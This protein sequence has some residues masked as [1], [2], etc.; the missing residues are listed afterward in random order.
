MAVT[1]A[2]QPYKLCGA[3]RARCKTLLL[4]RSKTR[5]REGS[6]QPCSENVE[7]FWMSQLL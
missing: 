5:L 2:T 7:D 3:F 1:S 6:A 4:C